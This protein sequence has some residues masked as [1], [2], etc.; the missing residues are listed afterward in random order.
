[1]KFTKAVI[2]TTLLLTGCATQNDSQY[3]Q[4]AIPERVQAW[5][6]VAR[7]YIRL[8]QY[9]N[10][11]GPL[12]EAL[13]INPKAS[14]SLML[15][16]LVFQH[17]GEQETADIYYKKA[18]AEAPDDSIINNNYGAFLLN[19]QRYSDACGYLA[20]AANDPLYNQRV[21]ALENLA[22]C[23]SRSNQAE[24]A[25]Q[26]YLQVL[27]LNPNSAS[28]LVE[29]ATIEFERKEL[30]K[31][32]KYF[33]RFSSLVRLHQ[34]EHTAKSLYLGVLLSRQNSDPGKAATYALILKNIYP[35]SIEYQRY[36][37]AR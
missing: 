3:Q 30:G 25:E 16:A 22:S 1:V 36:K 9:E 7:E 4:R 14:A 27:R 15:M 33:E 13:N 34:G 35:D 28:A 29:L 24:Q 5:N 20:K 8:E 18:L 26:T 32:F 2:V 19:T 17:Q 37:E 6:N 12:K 21:W 23:Y 31:S 10:A 11:K